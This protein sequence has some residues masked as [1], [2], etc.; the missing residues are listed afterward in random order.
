M[1]RINSPTATAALVKRVAPALNHGD[2]LKYV[3]RAA[4]ARPVYTYH[5]CDVPTSYLYLSKHQQ[6][7]QTVL[8]EPGSSGGYTAYTTTQRFDQSV[9][10]GDVLLEGQLKPSTALEPE[11]FLVSD[12]VMYRG[13]LMN[14]TPLYRRL[15]LCNRLIDYYYVYDPILAGPLRIQVKEHTTEEFLSSFTEYVHA[16]CYRGKVQSMD[17]NASTLAVLHA[18]H[19]TLVELPTVV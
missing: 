8:L 16:C 14:R 17:S 19:S 10:D 9:F 2:A 7:N 5:L 13:R 1:R 6:R 12:I 4:D 11:V 15:Q 3:E 18:N